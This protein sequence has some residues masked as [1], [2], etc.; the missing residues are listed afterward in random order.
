[1][2][3]SRKHSMIVRLLLIL[4]FLLT[5][6]DLVAQPQNLATRLVAM[7]ESQDT[8][9]AVELLTGRFQNSWPL[10]IHYT[11]RDSANLQLKLFKSNRPLRTSVHNLPYFDTFFDAKNDSL[12]EFTVIKRTQ[13]ILQPIEYPYFILTKCPAGSLTFVVLDSTTAT[14]TSKCIPIPQCSTRVITIVKEVKIPEPRFLNYRV[15]SSGVIS[16]GSLGWFLNE[17]AKALN[18]FESY[19]NAKYRTDVV[20]YRINTEK[21]RVRRNIA[22]TIS[23][24]AGVTFAYFFLKDLF[25]PPREKV[26]RTYQTHSGLKDRL[27]FG[28]LPGSG[29]NTL[30]FSLLIGL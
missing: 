21:H 26:I 28:L 6:E 29:A 2:H 10:L 8:T 24:A 7:I 14:F 23:A 5:K 12:I 4:I 9:K 16:L 19:T 1:M 15:L 27:Q 11:G 17:R 25:C 20:T 18:D 13:G 3:L 30:Q 22:G